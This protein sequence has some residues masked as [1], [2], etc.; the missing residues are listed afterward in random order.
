[1]QDHLEVILKLFY[2]GT[3]QKVLTYIGRHC[4]KC[5]I[6]YTCTSRLMYYICLSMSAILLVL[7]CNVHTA[8]GPQYT[9]LS[10][11]LIW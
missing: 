1:M 7:Y 8:Q 2:Y 3:F 9:L 6:S 4:D 5:N 11:V 10:A